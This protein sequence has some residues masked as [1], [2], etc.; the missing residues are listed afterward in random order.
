MCTHNVGYGVVLLF[1]AEHQR[2][3]GQSESHCHDN[4]FVLLC[5]SEAYELLKAHLVLVHNQ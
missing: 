5:E 3:A 4:V 2:L 1:V